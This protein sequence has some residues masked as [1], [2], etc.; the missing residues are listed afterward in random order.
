MNFPEE[1][2]SPEYFI[3]KIN[4]QL[5]N[6]NSTV[7]KIANSKI[8][9]IINK[10]AVKEFLKLN[11]RNKIMQLDDLIGKMFAES[12]FNDIIDCLEDFADT[13]KIVVKIKILKKILLSIE[14]F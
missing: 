12:K 8:F 5:E 4:E 10:D 9:Q 7:I 2:I 14:Y 13:H 3:E 11:K 1:K 6:E